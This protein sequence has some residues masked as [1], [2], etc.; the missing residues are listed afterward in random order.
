MHQD[1]APRHLLG[2]MEDASWLRVSMLTMTHCD[3]LLLGSQR[4][5][6]R[7]SNGFRL[8][9]FRFRVE[10]FGARSENLGSGVQAW[11]NAGFLVTCRIARLVQAVRWIEQVSQAPFLGAV[12]FGLLVLAA[13]SGKVRSTSIGTIIIGLLCALQGY[14]KYQNKYWPW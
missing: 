7:L 5:F 10:D 6:F 14:G 13:N 9:V 11:V 3:L 2:A 1:K 8:R 12:P 4:A